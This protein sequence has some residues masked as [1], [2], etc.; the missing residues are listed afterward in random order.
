MFLLAAVLSP[1]ARAADIYIAQ[2]SAGSATGSSCANALA[3]SAWSSAGNWVAGNTLHVC[4]TYTGALNGNAITALASGSSGNP[5]TIKFETGALLTSPAWSATS[6]AINCAGQSYITIDGGTNG[7]INDTANGDSLANQVLS[8]GIVGSAACPNLTVQN[9]TI[10]NIY[11]RVQ[12]A[13]GLDD[14]TCINFVG[15]NS[16]ITHNSLDHCRT[17]IGAVNQSHVEIS[18]NSTSYMDH[19]IS[20]GAGG[21][22][23]FV[24]DLKIHDNDFGTG[25]Y[26]YDNSANDYHHDA[27]I[28]QCES[29]FNPCVTA[30]LIYNNFFHGVWSE[31]VTTTHTTAIIFLDDYPTNQIQAE[32]F[33]NVIALASGD[34]GMA[35]GY[36]TYGQVNQIYN[37]V[38]IGQTSGNACLQ[39]AD[40][41]SIIIKNNIFSG[42]GNAIY[43][44]GAT[45]HLVVD[46]NLYYNVTSD[47]WQGDSFAQWQAAG[48]DTHGKNGSNPNFNASAPPYT[49]Q[50][51]SPAIGA[52]VN[53]TS[54]GITLL[55]TGAPQTFGNTGSCGTGCLTRAAS[56]NWDSGAYPVSGAGTPPTL[57]PSL[58]YGN[59]NQGQSALLTTTLTNNSGSTISITSTAYGGANS[60]DF[61]TSSTTCGATLAT[62]STCTY[63]IKFLPT[64]QYWTVEAG[65]FSVTFTGTTGSPVSITMGGTSFNPNP[66]ATQKQFMTKLMLQQPVMMY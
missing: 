23:P 7:T 5:I 37:N 64:A 58:S 33:N 38:V 36:I 20:A 29:S 39:G 47:G 19:P 56:G 30:V 62:G 41:N 55:D 17:G 6:G 48:F 57:S 1:C 42:C 4:G 22:G 59:V 34:Q 14:S 35:N 40:Q 8:Q 63:T 43:S 61:S 25:A 16:L 50:A 27:I 66:G 13:A 46:Y 32:T 53:L 9:M 60:A 31:D 51:G 12:G 3:W 18:F 15:S 24:T 45:G 21:G 65:T 10:T 52:G 54:L 49:L 11:V 28:V 2:N 44:G 26:I